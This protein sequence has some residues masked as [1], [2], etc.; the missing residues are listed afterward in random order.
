VSSDD[1]FFEE[2]FGLLLLIADDLVGQEDFSCVLS[3]D[4]ARAVG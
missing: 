2:N 1:G 3:K 4:L